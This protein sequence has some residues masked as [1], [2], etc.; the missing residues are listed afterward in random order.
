MSRQDHFSDIVFIFRVSFSMSALC[1]KIL[2]SPLVICNL[3]PMQISLC[4]TKYYDGKNSALLQL[5]QV[6]AM[7]ELCQG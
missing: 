7:L 1:S 5:S 2:S 3:H 6:R 4:D